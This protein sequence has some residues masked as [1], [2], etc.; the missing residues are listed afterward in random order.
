[1]EIPTTQTAIELIGPEQLRLNPSKPVYQPGPYQVL[2]KVEA[3]GLCFSDLKLLAQFDKHPRKSEILSG[4]EPAVLSEFP[5]YCPGPKPTVPGHEISCVI[6]AV[7]SKVRRH[8]VGQT[9]LVQTDYRWLKTASSNAAVGYNFEGALQQY[10]LFDERVYVDP[11]TGDSFLIPVQADIAA[12]AGALVEPWACVESSYV[13]QERQTIR[14][15]GRL[16]VA[17]DEGRRIQGLRESFTAGLPSSAV[18]WSPQPLPTDWA[19]GICLSVVRTPEGL[20]DGSF[21]DIVYFGCRREIIEILNDKL[22]A[23]GILNIVL[24]GRRIGQPVSIGVG[25]V[26]YGMTRWIGTTSDDAFDSYRTIPSTGEIRDGEQAVVI[27]AG[28]PMGQMHVIRILCSGR[29]NLSVTAT[30]LDEH[31]LAS[32]EKKVRPLLKSRPAQYRSI[33]TSAQPDTDTYSYFALM[34][35][36][37]ALVAD[38]VARSRPNA[39]INIFAGIPAAVRQEIDLDRYIANRCYLFGTSGSRLQDMQ[40]VLDKVLSGQ[41]DTNCSVDAVCGMAGAVEGIQAVKNRTLSGKIVVYP[42]L[43]KMPLMTLEQLARKWPPLAEK[44][45]DGIWTKE[46]EQTLLQLAQ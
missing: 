44:M 6:V 3:V 14:P 26:H 25:R 22:A 7:G 9:V 35:P 10:I 13:T 36:V 11:E 18:L 45:P 4:I 28:G 27:G 38:A 16:L 12:S 31:R 21:D 29:K 30:D 20:P 40:I 32:L 34:A 15:G 24:G 17:V 1:M 46:A 2:A 23:G 19:S 42:A 33:V 39:L 37:G 43:E 41:L 5:S 8:H